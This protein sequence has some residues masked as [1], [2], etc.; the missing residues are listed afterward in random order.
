MQLI[1]FIFMLQWIANAVNDMYAD[2]I[3]TVILQ[4][5]SNPTAVQSMCQL[6]ITNVPKF[7][8]VAML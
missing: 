1:F 4:V 2:A 7:S 5:D 8:D 3:L 6:S